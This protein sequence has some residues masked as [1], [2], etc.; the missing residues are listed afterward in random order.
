MNTKRVSLAEADGHMAELFAAAKRGEE[1]VIEDDEH[2]QVKLVTLPRV[3]KPRVLGLHAGLVDIGD[4]FNEPLPES[5]WLG[6]QP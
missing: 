5:F 4:D 3:R 2:N 6:G 1:V